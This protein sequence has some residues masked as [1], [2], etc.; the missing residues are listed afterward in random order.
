MSV[1]YNQKIER[2]N[3]M[4]QKNKPGFKT[5]EFWVSLISMILISGFGMDPETVNTTAQGGMAGIAGLYAVGR[6][7]VKA[8]EK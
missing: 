4:S 5:S 2:K 8:F 1:L 6:S 7:I 3:I